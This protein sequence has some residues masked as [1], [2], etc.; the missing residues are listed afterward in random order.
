MTAI[1]LADLDIT[2]VTAMAA[3]DDHLVVVEIFFQPVRNRVHRI[4]YDGVI[5]ETIELP[6]G[7]RL[8]DGLSG[9]RSGADRM[10]ALEFRGG[11]A[12]G[13]WD[14]DG[15]VF[16]MMP[17]LVEG[18]VIVTPV[19]PD[20]EIGAVLITGDFTS[21]LGGLRYLGTAAGGDH[22]IERIDV[23]ATDPAFDVL[24][25]IEWYGADGALLGS[26]RIPTLLEQHI[27]TPP[28]V[29]MLPDGGV[30]VLLALENEVRIE[31]LERTPGRITE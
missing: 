3:N 6:P 28:G 19:P 18:G 30:A 11:S 31:L 8:E 15:R 22:V 29:A 10:I 26:A 16:E 13:V 5:V 2:S 12:F 25:T 20:I 4:G 14:P 23:L 27:S 21:G 1:D 9:V 7:F 17:T 24:S